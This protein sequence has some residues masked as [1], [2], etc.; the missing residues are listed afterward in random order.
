[1]LNRPLTKIHLASLR[2]QK[3]GNRLALALK[4]VGISQDELSYE[5]RIAR[6]YISDVAGNRYR[7]ITVENA[8]RFA[9]FFEVAIADLFPPLTDIELSPKKRLKRKVA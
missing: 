4:L 7:T 6:S 1:M 5:L 2:R 9:A 8:H 3:K